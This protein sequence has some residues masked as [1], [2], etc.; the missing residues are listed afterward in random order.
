M[1]IESD[2]TI[3][4]NNS[5]LILQIVRT[6]FDHMLYRKKRLRIKLLPHWKNWDKNLKKD[7]WNICGETMKKLKY[8]P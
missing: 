2:R 5:F 6:I 7:Y 3:L 4:I 8:K 1:Q